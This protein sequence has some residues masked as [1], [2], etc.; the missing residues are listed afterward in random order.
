[1]SSRAAAPAVTGVAPDRGLSR[2]GCRSLALA[3]L[4]A[5]VALGQDSQPSRISGEER[6]SDWL[7]DLNALTVELPKHHLNAFFKT[8]REEFLTASAELRRDIPSLAD[9]DIVVRMMR[10]VAK[11]G[12]AHTTLDTSSVMKDGGLYPFAANWFSDGIFITHAPTGR[13]ELV[14]ARILKIED[15]PVEEAARRVGAVYPAENDAM[16]RNQIR[17]TLNSAD[18]LAAV[19][20]AKSDRTITLTIRENDTQ[21][22]VE[23]KA[24]PPTEYNKWVSRPA[25]D[26]LPLYRQ[27]RPRANW[28]EPLPAGKAIYVQYGRCADEAGQTV[29]QFTEDLLKK[30]DEMSASRVILDVRRNGGGNSALAMPLTIG[31]GKREKLRERGGVIVIIGRATFSSAQL[32]ANEWRHALGAVVVGEPTGQKPNAYGEIKNFELPHSRMK[33]WYSTK[34][35]RTDSADP[36]SMTPDLDVSV[37]SADYFSGKDPALEAAL[38]YQAEAE[39]EP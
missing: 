15:L 21:S 16:F 4:C 25:A 17:R 23:L 39:P 2:T 30:I 32:N 26:A 5:A 34:F 38:A 11:I 13:E 24:A 19:G 27:E 22:A 6:V 35:F 12:D 36:P 33:V 18:L 31:L 14:G 28:F 20:V 8:S 3:V 37:A 29:A 7:D 1:M 9:R 10:L